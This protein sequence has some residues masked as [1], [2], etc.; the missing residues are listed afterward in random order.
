LEE[1][2]PKEGGMMH[3]LTRE[4]IQTILAIVQDYLETGNPN[5][6]L[7]SG[8]VPLIEHIFSVAHDT[9]GVVLQ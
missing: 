1:G 4:D 7:L 5:P 8:S 2:T 6:E 3:L 9:K